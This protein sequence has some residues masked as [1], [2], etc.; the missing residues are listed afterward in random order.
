MQN[1]LKVKSSVRHKEGLEVV[2]Q[3]YDYYQRKANGQ[4]SS[5]QAKSGISLAKIHIKLGCPG[6]AVELI[7]EGT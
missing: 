1:M 2:K 7:N 6:K 4:P 3:A 5:L